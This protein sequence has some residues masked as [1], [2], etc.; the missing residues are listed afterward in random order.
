M[1]QCFS[2]ITVSIGGTCLH[3]TREIVENDPKERVKQNDN[4]VWQQK[5]QLACGQYRYPSVGTG[6]RV[7]TNISVLTG[8]SVPIPKKQYRYPR[9]RYPKPSTDTPC[10]FLSQGIPVANLRIDTQGEYRYPRGGTDTLKGGIDTLC[11]KCATASFFLQVSTDTHC[12]RKAV[13]A[14]KCL[15]RLQTTLNGHQRLQTQLGP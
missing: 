13:T 7:L 12:T 10:I 15:Q 9:Y 2:S 1:Y 8:P 11:F 6:T 5:C 3:P 14:G 4:V